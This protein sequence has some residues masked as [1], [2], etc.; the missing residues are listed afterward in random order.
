MVGYIE[1]WHI[2]L[3][4]IHAFDRELGDASLYDLLVELCHDL[5]LEL[6]GGLQSCNHGTQLLDV[7]IGKD[8]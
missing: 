4:L 3:Q 5:R 1:V 6:L 7:L 8:V 2:F